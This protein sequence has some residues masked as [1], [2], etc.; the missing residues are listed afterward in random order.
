MQIFYAKS[1]KNFIKTMHYFFQKNKE[2]IEKMLL[3]RWPTIKNMKTK[4]N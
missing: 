4:L 3:G 1:I 2:K